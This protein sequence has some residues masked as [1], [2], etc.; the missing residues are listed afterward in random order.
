MV[1]LWQLHY[2]LINQS[3]AKWHFCSPIIRNHFEF[4]QKKL[5]FAWTSVSLWLIGTFLQPFAVSTVVT[6]N[7]C[8]DIHPKFSFWELAWIA[9]FEFCSNWRKM[10][11]GPPLFRLAVYIQISINGLALIEQRIQ[12]VSKFD[13]R[14]PLWT[15]S[16]AS[17]QSVVHWVGRVLN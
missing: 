8:F 10:F 11:K 17:I 5:V 14:Y 13:K 7:S 6:L 3:E 2:W 1:A 4:I 9:K 15:F 12:G 16:H